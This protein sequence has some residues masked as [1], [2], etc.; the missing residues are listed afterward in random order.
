VVAD[1]DAESAVERELVL[2]LASVL[3]RFETAIFEAVSNEPSKPEP[4]Y[5]GLTLIAGADLSKRDQSRITAARRSDAAARSES[6]LD[7]K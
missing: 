2:R 6:S 7:R 3:W 4:G 5:L 1:F